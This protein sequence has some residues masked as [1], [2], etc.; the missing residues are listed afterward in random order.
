MLPS[1]PPYI[2]SYPLVSLASTLSSAWVSRLQ[3]TTAP[4]RNIHMTTHPGLIDTAYHVTEPID[5][6]ELIAAQD[7]NA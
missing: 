2:A 7:D 1:L 5:M 4:E 6:T 3:L